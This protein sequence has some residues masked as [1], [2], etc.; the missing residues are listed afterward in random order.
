MKKF[1]IRYVVFGILAVILI[2][3]G[4]TLLRIA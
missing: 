1:K 2:Y 3:V 4:Y